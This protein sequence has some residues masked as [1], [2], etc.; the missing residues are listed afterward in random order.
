VKDR[1]GPP[2]ERPDED[3]RIGEQVP[4]QG[5][6]RMRDEPDPE[7][8]KRERQ[9][10]EERCRRR[11]AGAS[12]RPARHR[13]A[14]G[15]HSHASKRGRASTLKRTSSPERGGRR[16]P[17]TPRR[18][19]PAPRPSRVCDSSQMMP[20]RH[21]SPC[22]SVGNAY[23]VGVRC[24]PRLEAPACGARDATEA[25]RTPTRHS[26][27]ASQRRSLFDSMAIDGRDCQYR[28]VRHGPL[29]QLAVG[30]RPPSHS[31]TRKHDLDSFGFLVDRDHLA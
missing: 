4:D 11:P 17:R 13:P 15:S 20:R 1:V 10:R 8:E 5:S 9:V 29:I 6:L 28:Q 12:P 30:K 14:C 31:A 7:E 26:L 19:S 25:S 3:L 27:A 16:K 22:P 24:Q 2:R 18:C 21:R 23:A